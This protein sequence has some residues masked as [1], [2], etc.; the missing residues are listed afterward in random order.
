MSSRAIVTWPVSY[1]IFGVLQPTIATTPRISP[2]AQQRQQL[3]RAAERVEHRLRG[4]AGHDL[5][6]VRRDVHLG[7]VAARERLDGDPRDAHRVVVERLGVLGV[8]R[9]VRR[10][11]DAVAAARRDDLGAEAL[12]DGRHAGQDA[13]HVDDD[14]VDR[15]RPDDEL[16]PHRAGHRRDAVARERLVTG[17]AHAAD[18]DAG[19]ALLARERLDLL[20]AQ[21]LEHLLEHHRRVPVHEDVDVVGLEHAVVHLGCRGLGHAEQDVRERPTR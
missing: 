17:A 20:G 21:L 19:R 15:A 13:L 9:D 10:A 11:G 16:L 18:D 7:A 14:R 2:L 1:A 8:E 12:G 5:R 4:E 3:A 6:R